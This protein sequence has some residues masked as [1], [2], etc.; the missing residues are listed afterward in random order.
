LL[1]KKL[2]LVFFV[3]VSCGCLGSFCE[4]PY[5]RVGGEC[6]LD[7][8]VDGVCDFE[9]VSNVSS[10][11]V[12]RCSGFS[13]LRCFNRTVRLSG[14]SRTLS[15]SFVNDAG[16]PV[17]IRS[18]EVGGDCIGGSGN[19]SEVLLLAGDVAVFSCETVDLEPG[20]G[21]NADV[22]ITYEAGFGKTVKTRKDTGGITG[23]VE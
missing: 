1:V 20:E 11:G 13:A 4:K 5:T 21:F 8:D 23:I 2:A 10:A 6:C 14:G 3:V 15:A 16:V 18:V 12:G 7:V 19:F 17:K 9:A 22:Y